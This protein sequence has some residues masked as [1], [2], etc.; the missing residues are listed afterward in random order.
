MT[1]RITDDEFD[2]AQREIDKRRQ[3]R[4]GTAERAAADAINAEWERLCTACQSP[5]AADRQR[6]DVAIRAFAVQHDLIKDA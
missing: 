3:A 5:R 6:A 1:K 4:R 2:A